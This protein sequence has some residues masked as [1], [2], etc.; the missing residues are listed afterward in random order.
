MNH[1]ADR[2]GEELKLMNGYR[3]TPG[4]HGAL[5]FDASKIDMVSLPDS[6]D[7]R[8]YGKLQRKQCHKLRLTG[9]QMKTVEM[10]LAAYVNC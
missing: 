1:L 6:V 8:L 3:H 2:S 5:V 4:D 9:E 10:I 7:W